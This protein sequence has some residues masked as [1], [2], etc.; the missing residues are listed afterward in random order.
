MSTTWTNWGRN[1]SARPERTLTP[2]DADEVAEVL[3]AAHRAGRRVKVVGSGH[4]FTGIAA[5]AQDQLRLDALSGVLAVDVTRR[6]ATVLAGTPLHV[7]NPLLW[8]LG[9]SMPNLGDIDRQTIAGAV[10]TGTHGTGAALQGLA[11]AVR[12]L[13]LVTG[14]GSVVR[15]DADEQPELFAAARV[16]LGAL[17]VITEV[18][19][20]LVPSFR[21]RAVERPAALEPF[22]EQVQDL[23]DTHRH[24]EL[25]WFP[26]TERVLTKCNDIV[27]GRDPGR[28]LPRWREQLDDHLL[29][30][31][32]FEGVNRAV[33]RRPALARRVNPLSARAL[34]AREYTDAAYKVLCTRREVRFTESEYAVPRRSLGPVLLAL[35]R[36]V[37]T[38]DEHVAFPVEVRFAAADDIWLSTAYERDNAYIAVH[39]YHRMDGARYFAAFEAIAREHGGRPHWGKVHGLDADTLRTLYPRYDDF[40]AVR[41]RLDPARTF[42]NSYLERVLPS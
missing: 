27:D 34:S 4:S 9:L 38:H 24:V 1:Q 21:L 11:A 14:D 25:Y 19:L 37:D 22:L 5:P 12:G 28:P 33:A 42:T 6:R 35:K 30:G 13:T 29:A 40:V 36:W 20:Q 17:G 10:A 15:C 32:A 26:H 3:T 31:I 2:R 7:L 16:G 39:Q 41:D 18:E 8:Q 23:A